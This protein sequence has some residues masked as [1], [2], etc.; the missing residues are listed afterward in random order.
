MSLSVPVSLKRRSKGPILGPSTDAG[1]GLAVSPFVID[2]VKPVKG[3]WDGEFEKNSSELVNRPVGDIPSEGVRSPEDGEGDPP[4]A[5]WAFPRSYPQAMVGSSGCAKPRNLGLRTGGRS[6]DTGRLVCETPKP[7][8]TAPVL[9]V[10]RWV[11][12]RE[13]R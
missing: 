12:P 3:R 6:P 11:I 1:A 5:A 8:P 2:K 7:G 4:C 9:I 13:T 10:A